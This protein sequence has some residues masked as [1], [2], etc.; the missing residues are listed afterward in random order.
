MI[1]N[2]Q[3]MVDAVKLIIMTL[4][5]GREGHRQIQRRIFWATGGREK[6]RWKA[7]RGQDSLPL[8][9]GS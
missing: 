7:T 9:W 6:K 1:Y 5:A 4:G 3:N 2:H 8:W